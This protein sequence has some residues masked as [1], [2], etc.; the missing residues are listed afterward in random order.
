MIISLIIAFLIIMLIGELSALSVYG[1]ILSDKELVP[2]LEKHLGD[3][4]INNFSWENKNKMLYSFNLPYIA[5]R[6]SSFMVGWHIEDY[7]QVP[8]WSKA[9]KIINDYFNNLPKPPLKPNL[10]DL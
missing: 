4:T 2:F 9:S 5:E 3:Y 10:K 8:R 6:K 1:K 7:G